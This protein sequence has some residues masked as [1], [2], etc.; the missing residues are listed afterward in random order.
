MDHPRVVEVLVTN[1]CSM[2]VTKKRP[3]GEGFLG[4]S[5]GKT[6]FLFGLKGATRCFGG[7]GAGIREEEVMQTKSVF[8]EE[9]R[10]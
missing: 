5:E 2:V 9:Q 1:P 6:R 10:T 3:K 8:S 4:C 7:T